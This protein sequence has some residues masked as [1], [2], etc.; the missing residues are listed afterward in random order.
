[1]FV[2]QVKSQFRNNSKVLYLKF[3]DTYNIQYRKK[4]FSPILQNILLSLEVFR[5]PRES[6][7]QI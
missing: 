3:K 6:N 4:A 1:M 2:K 5:C 7:H